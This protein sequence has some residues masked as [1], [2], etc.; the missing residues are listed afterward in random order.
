M[1]GGRLLVRSAVV[2]VEE[3]A[4]GDE[5]ARRAF[6]LVCSFASDSTLLG[7]GWPA[8][9]GDAASG[10]ENGRDTR[11]TGPVGAPAAPPSSSAVG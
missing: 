8:T 2:G 1:A 6:A 3:H 4:P 5:E 11:Q 7:P 9:I 10:E